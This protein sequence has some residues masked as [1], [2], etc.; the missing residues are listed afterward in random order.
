VPPAIH[1]REGEKEEKGRQTEGGGTVR[2]GDGG[3]QQRS[4]QRF[5]VKRHRCEGGTKNKKATGGKRNQRRIIP[6]EK[7]INGKI[8]NEHSLLSFESKN[9]TDSNNSSMKFP[10]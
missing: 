2:T 8:P 3:V 4:V 9:T 6:S 5:G 1:G 10:R 7:P